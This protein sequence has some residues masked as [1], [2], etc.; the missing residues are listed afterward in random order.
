MPVVAE[1]S[2]ENDIVAGEPSL[3]GLSRRLLTVMHARRV[4]RI[5]FKNQQA[6]YAQIVVRLRQPSQNQ[7]LFGFI[8]T[9]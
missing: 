3:D 7:T 9:I 5:L 6:G 4:E 1:R 2:R 8:H